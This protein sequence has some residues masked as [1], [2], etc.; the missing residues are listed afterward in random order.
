M[1]TLS[2]VMFDV[3]THDGLDLSDSSSKLVPPNEMKQ[4]KR[5]EGLV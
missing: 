4:I 5:V 1:G 3:K 2:S